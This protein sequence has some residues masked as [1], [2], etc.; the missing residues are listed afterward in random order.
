MLVYKGRVAFLG[1]VL[2]NSMWSWVEVM[3]LVSVDNRL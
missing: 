2:Y 3:N 1:L